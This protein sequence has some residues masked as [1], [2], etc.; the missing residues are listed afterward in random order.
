M[1]KFWLDARKWDRDL[2]TTA[3]ESGAD[4]V[5]VLGEYVDGVRELGLIQTR[6]SSSWRSTAKRTKLRRSSMA[7]PE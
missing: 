5:F 2:V 3:L 7:L 6:M 1:K 4:A